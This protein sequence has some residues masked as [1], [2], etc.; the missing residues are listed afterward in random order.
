[1]KFY[2]L[3]FLLGIATI[4]AIAQTGNIAGKVT[5]ESNNPLVGV[6]IIVK[7][8]KKKGTQT[9]N[10]G[11]FKLNEVPTG[12]QTLLFSYL[13][14]N[15][16]EIKVTVTDGGT[17]NLSS[18]ALAEKSELM[19]EVVIEGNKTNKF[20]TESS[21]YVSKLPLG[22]LENPQVYNVVSA[23]LLKEQA[24][25]NFDDAL[26]NVPGLQKL[27]ESTGR[28]G[29]GAG[30]FSLRGFSIQPTMLNG[31]PAL[32]NGSPDP[33]NIERIEVLKGPSGTLFG[34]SLISYGGLIN[35]VTKKPY[36][37]FGGEI[38][39]TTGSY[40][41][42]RITA[43]V[44]T[45][46]DSEGKALLRVN[47][48]YHTQN[49]FQDAGMKES[50]FIA[51][52]LAYKASDRLSFLVVTEFLQGKQTNPTMLFLNR[53]NPL[54]VDNIDDLGYDYN[55]S[56]T[57]NNL[58]I[59]NPTL[60]LQAQAN[61][62]ISDSWTSQTAIS[63]GS[64][65]SDGYYSYLYEYTHLFSAYI[66]DGSVFNRF[67]SK[68]NTDIIST[69]LQQNF[70]GDFKIGS[71]RNRMVVGF[72]YM[73][74]KT[75]NN[76]TG[77]VSNGIVYMGNETPEMVYNVVY[78]GTE[79]PNYDSGILSQPGMDALLDSA[80]VS[81]SESVNRVFG[82]YI[83]DVINITANLS[84]MAS[85]RVDRFE[86]DPE[87]D[88]DDQTALSPKFGIT[89]QPVLDKVSIFANYMNGFQNVAAQTVADA[90]GSNPRIK[91]FDPERANQFEVGAK[92]NLLENK[93]ST[94]IS[95]YDI[96]VSNQ[97]MSDPNNINNSIQ[98]GEVDSKGFEVDVVANPVNGWN[99][100]LGYSHNESEILNADNL[101]GKRPLSAGPEDMVNFWTSYKFQEST[102]LKGFGLGFG[103][104]YAG[105][106]YA[107]NYEAT[108]DFMLPSYTILN[109]SIF[110]E[111][112]KYRI[113]LNVNNLSD[114]K[115]YKGWSTINP[116]MTRNILASFAFRF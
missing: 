16:Q 32:T 29:D 15:S 17:T 71:V 3:L 10:T 88:N 105:E 100:I 116:Q 75:I 1:M 12:N 42:N 45:P 89:Y 69:D 8:L 85:L 98:D 61:Y 47:A 20:Y 36:E 28:G 39:Y 99:V 73:E 26:N 112:D 66:S 96:T 67:V 106:A 74:A 5:D 65:K 38:S 79:V 4:N 51:P 80:V 9:D 107:I 2:T 110:Y 101:V 21:P 40:G 19:S 83:S 52:T 46:L 84:V 115:Y 57:S 78:G 53:S 56:Y 114:Q 35:I 41:L 76:S 48:A 103:L 87:D 58:T 94:T 7:G 13:G 18:L 55:R 64:A 25:T 22:N 27:W 102:A 54:T 111:A 6:N 72:D 108:G 37:T 34:S 70:I 81:N 97:V 113:A 44:N 43:D 104:N 23:L 50:F 95:Y 11:S 68:Q 59:K 30:Y 82:A 49:S 60:S 33:A 24:V 31:L 86:G 93:I 109:S 62:K 91:Q 63:K 90:D 77:Y 92:V 14:Y